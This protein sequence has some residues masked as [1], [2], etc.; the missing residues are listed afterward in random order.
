MI[1]V[2]VISA[3]DVLR[4]LFLFVELDL[5]IG[6]LLCQLQE[7]LLLLERRLLELVNQSRAFF[8]L[9]ADDAELP[10]ELIDIFRRLHL[11]G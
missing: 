7:L 6:H 3:L 4:Q 2:E 8:K 9:L 5:E 10:F 1:V 11:R